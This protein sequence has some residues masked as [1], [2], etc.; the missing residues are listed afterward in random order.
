MSYFKYAERNADSQ[1]NWAEVGK[2]ISDMLSETNRVR[3][4]KKDALDVAQREAM[5]YIADTP[6]GEHTGARESILGYADK[7]SNRMR[8]AKKLM[9]Q[10]QMSVK[11]YTVFRQNLTDNTNLAFNA[12]KSYQER[13]SDVM[14][15]VADKRYSQLLAENF[16]EAEGFGNWGNIGWEIAPN[17]TVLAGKMIEQEV[18]GKKVKTL[19]KSPGGMRSMDY[20]NQ[21][22]L[23]NV[24]FYD[25]ESKVNSWADTLGK[26]KK[27]LVVLGK[28]Q[29][30]G[31]ITSV[32][33]ITSR[34][35][36]LPGT[37]DVL[38]NFLQGENDQIASIVG[39][40]LDASRVLVDSAVFAPNGKQYRS[41]TSEE[42]AKKN[43]E[44]ILK[45]VDPDS[46]G[47]KYV[48]SPNQQEDA[49]EFIRS[50]MRAKYDYEEESQ[51]VGAVSRDEESEASI[52]RKEEQKEKDNALGTWGDV[53]KATTPAGKQAALETILGSKLAQDRGL[54]DIDTTSQPGKIIFKYA[55]PV[56]NRVLDYDPNTTT[57][58]QWNELGNEV[59]GID[60]VAEVMKRNK[61]GDPN[62]KM[63]A[64]QKDFTGVKAGRTP[65]KDPIVEFDN[66]I[67][68]IPANIFKGSDKVASA[69]LT[70]LLKGTNI[71]IK[72]NTGVN[73]FQ[74]VNF[75]YKGK[76]KVITF[77]DPFSD[78]TPE[79][80]K[81]EL[82]SWV[83]EVVSKEDKEDMLKKGAIGGSGNTGKYNKK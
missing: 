46:G 71:V 20:L 35:D 50:Q 24:D 10:G 45:V 27:T 69:A 39:E 19:D 79:E 47:F 7:A 32:D 75:S 23:S 66:K 36:L 1:I 65:V 4:E 63:G 30:Q 25:Y 78:A 59:H 56:K 83:N 73:P 82:E 74:S 68:A 60:N 22:L 43:P 29:K 61:G 3:E 54:L 80:L 18:D 72:P 26:E 8:I 33:D 67:K 52:K 28:I 44:A 42:D 11:D 57:L 76:D 38:F 81:Q 2:G 12:N 55:D 53:F 40:P 58:R 15:G 9:E 6:N 21:I 62:M 70:K 16:E 17:G 51:V 64:N 31:K 41:T 14:K 77:N 48:I 49:N 5:Q 13:Y 34:E 37:Q